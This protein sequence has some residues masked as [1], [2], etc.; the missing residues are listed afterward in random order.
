MS[1]IVVGTW[2][3]WEKNQGGGSTTMDRWNDK[4]IQPYLKPPP[5]RILDVGC[6]PHGDLVKLL[7]SKQYDAYGI[8]I[9]L[10][11]TGPYY[12]RRASLEDPPDKIDNEPYDLILCF[13]T[14]EHILHDY[15]ALCAMRR[16]LH[17]NGTL[18]VSVPN[19]TGGE[20]YPFHVRNYQ[21]WSLKILLNY[22]GFTDVE[23]KPSPGGNGILAIARPFSQ[24]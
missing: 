9:R 13:E 12:L 17:P 20:N 16:W 11:V 4:L 18:L 2:K 7:R 6:G 19:M 24:P 3:D 8:D 5:L 15:E 22:S 1:D 10:P 14:L 21:P 23:V